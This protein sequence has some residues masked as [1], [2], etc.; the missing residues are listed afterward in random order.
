MR[1]VRQVAS[2]TVPC[3]LVGTKGDLSAGRQVSESDGEAI[4]HENGW[5]YVEVSAKEGYR[6]ASA[7]QRLVAKVFDDPVVQIPSKFD[8]DTEPPSQSADFLAEEEPPKLEERSEKPKQEGRTFYLWTK[9]G[10]VEWA[11]PDVSELED[12]PPEFRVDCECWLGDKR[13]FTQL[14]SITD[15]DNE[16]IFEV[17]P[18]PTGQLRFT[19]FTVAGNEEKKVGRVTC[20]VHRLPI[21]ERLTVVGSGQS[22]LLNIDAR[23]TPTRPGKGPRSRR[24]RVKS[25][26]IL[27]GKDPEE[28]RNAA[29]EAASKVYQEKVLWPFEDRPAQGRS[30]LSTRSGL[31]SRGGESRKPESMPIDELRCTVAA[32]EQKMRDVDQEIEQLEANV[33]EEESVE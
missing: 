22:T 29:R 1:I 19:V 7:F 23:I 21:A 33:D 4:A 18:N 17:P 20:P 13:K 12:A 9:I 32:L 27:Y 25:P 14:S 10:T 24:S 31:R 30:R 8:H 5:E 3:V 11:I 6:V 26:I 2:A 16:F 15:K 28:I